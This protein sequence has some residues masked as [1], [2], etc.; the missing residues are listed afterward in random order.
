ML[1]I[2]DIIPVKRDACKMLITFFCSCG[3]FSPDT[4]NNIRQGV[5]TWLN[6][7]KQRH[8]GQTLR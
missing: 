1:L 5:H 7:L 4:V 3:F 2:L 6:D 8:R